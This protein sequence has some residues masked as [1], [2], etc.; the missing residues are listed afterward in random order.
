MRIDILI[1]GQFPANATSK[2]LSECLY[3]M[4]HHFYDHPK[5]DVTF[6]YHTW[7]RSSMKTL[8]DSSIY[9]LKDAADN[10][11]YTPMPKAYNPYKSIP[12]FVDTPAWSEQLKKHEKVMRGID[13]S[14][15]PGHITRAL[16]QVSTCE[17][18]KTIDTPP[19]LYIRLRWDGMLS[20]AINFDKY[21]EAT[22]KNKVVTGFL[23]DH[24]PEDRHWDTRKKLETGVYHIE[25]SKSTNPKWHQRVFDGMIMFEP[26][27]FNTSVVDH[28][29]KTESLLAAEWGWWQIL[30]YANDNIDHVNI[31]GGLGIMRHME[32]NR[33]VR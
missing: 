16:Q 18:I 10:V 27:L 25:E 32:G 11:V 26:R 7:D 2:Q 19:D 14:P 4:H 6:R 22:Y 1:T 28:W 31:N 5:Y 9:L 17:L 12:R 24:A 8:L 3:R 29:W 13:E 20:Y 33:H 23:I 15:Q 30:C 21:I